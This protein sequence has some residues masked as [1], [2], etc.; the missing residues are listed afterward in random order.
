MAGHATGKKSGRIDENLEVH[1]HLMSPIILEQQVGHCGERRQEHRHPDPS[2][3]PS[4]VIETQ[5]EGDEVQ[6]QRE[7]PEKRDDRDIPTDLIGAR[8]KDD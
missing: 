7:H 8:E 1:T 3:V 5:N 4:R 6:A 2:V